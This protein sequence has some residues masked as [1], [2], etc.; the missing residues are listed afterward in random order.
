MH[1]I[2]VQIH[3]YTDLFSF[4]LF[5]FVD[6]YFLFCYRSFWL[7]KWQNIPD[8]NSP[9][10]GHLVHTTDQ[11]TNCIRRIALHIDSIFKTIILF[12]VCISRFIYAMSIVFVEINFAVIQFEKHHRSQQQKWK[13]K[14]KCALRKT[15]WKIAIQSI[16]TRLS[17]KWCTITATNF[18]AICQNNCI[19]KPNLN[20]ALARALFPLLLY[21]RKSMRA[22]CIRC[23]TLWAA[24]YFLSSVIVVTAT[25]QRFVGEY[26]E[27]HRERERESESKYTRYRPV[28]KTM[29][30]HLTHNSI[31][32]TFG[33]FIPPSLIN[34][35]VN[36]LFFRSRISFG[37]NQSSIQCT[38]PTAM[39]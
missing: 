39:W 23:C 5:W 34:C 36:Y 18:G 32:P 6:F 1:C 25:A 33:I 30:N 12:G 15:W 16:P 13:T 14:K 11:E 21:K 20:A 17:C 26:W 19:A 24:S 28:S 31:R 37:W 27:E 38:V 29:Q 9:A 3:R 2:F 10:L 35:C 22:Y 8:T 7:V 4:V